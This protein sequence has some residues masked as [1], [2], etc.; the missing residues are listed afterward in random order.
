MMAIESLKGYAFSEKYVQ[1]E[2]FAWMIK[3]TYRL[4]FFKET[5]L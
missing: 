4:K 2:T 3:N 1:R 5:L